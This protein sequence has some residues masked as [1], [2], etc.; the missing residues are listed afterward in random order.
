[1]VG[2]GS[3]LDDDKTGTSGV[4][5]GEVNAGLVAGDVET[6]DGS[7]LLER[8]RGGEAEDGGNCKG[9]ELHGECL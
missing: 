2:K 1:M 8:A 6:L 7:A 4:G 5:T 3:Y 9:G